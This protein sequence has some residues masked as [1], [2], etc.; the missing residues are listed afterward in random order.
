MIRA[1]VDERATT[2]FDNQVTRILLWAQVFSID[3]DDAI[4]EGGYVRAF[5]Q[6][7]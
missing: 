1:R 2:L 6:A 5:I 4:V 3:G 7:W